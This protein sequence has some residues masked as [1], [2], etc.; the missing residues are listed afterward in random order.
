MIETL[1]AF[2]G[3]LVNTLT[4]I[5][6][7]TVGLILKKQIPEKLTNAVMTAIGLCTIAI[8]VTGVIKGENQ[9]VMIISLVFGTIVGTLIDIDGKLSR[10][11]DKFQNKRAKNGNVHSDNATFSQGFVTASLLFCVGAM[12]IVGSMNA[13]I[14]GDN[15]MLYTKS[16]LDL[17]S[18][19]MLAA[20]LG[21]GVFCASGFVLV[22]QGAL[23]ALAMALGSFL[24]DFAVNELICTGS[25]M[26]TALGLN[27]I[28]VTKIKVANLLP[29]L[30]FVPFV[31]KIMELF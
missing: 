17:I 8:G 22:F 1:S 30:I 15:Q 24:N 31:C 11:G 3:V 12:T 10:L 29:G 9:L 14:S 19:S 18:S 23:V 20:S 27:L 25:V 21:F 13:G 7:S 6:G 28:G 5:I 26:I 4:V 2:S 16:V